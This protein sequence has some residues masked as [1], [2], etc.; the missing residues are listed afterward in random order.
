MLW[1]LNCLDTTEMRTK[2]LIQFV[3]DYLV[4]ENTVLFFF[5]NFV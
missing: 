2:A 4:Q 5:C 3:V 1:T